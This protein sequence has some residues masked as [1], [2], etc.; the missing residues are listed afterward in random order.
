LTLSPVSIT[1][2]DMPPSRDS[3]AREGPLPEGRP[4]FILAH[5]A[6][7]LRLFGWLAR[8]KPI[9]QVLTR[10]TR[11]GTASDRLPATTALVFRSGGT[12]SQAFEPW[13]DREL[14]SRVMASDATFLHH[15]VDRFRDLIVGADAGWVVTDSWQFYNVGHDLTHLAARVAAAEA[16]RRLGR[17]IP[18]LDY[19]VVPPAM[20]CRAPPARRSTR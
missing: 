6:H 12:I 4:V 2:D 18:V 7:E 8:T 13:L 16:G 17:P 11:S 5:P 1:P 14:Y 19:D 9:V 15:I 3:R 10:G 20:G